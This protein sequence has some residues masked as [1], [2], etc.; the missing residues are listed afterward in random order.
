MISKA[1]CTVF[2][3]ATLCDLSYPSIASATGHIELHAAAFHFQCIPTIWQEPSLKR[4]YCFSFSS[5][6]LCG[7]ASSAH[8]TFSSSSSD[9]S[10]TLL[11]FGQFMM[12]SKIPGQL[13][14][15]IQAHCAISVIQLVCVASVARC[16]EGTLLLNIQHRSGCQAARRNCATVT[17]TYEAA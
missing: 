8:D 2:S 3:S 15:L 14:F 11:P 6:G 7:G 12:T 4:R 17:N 5:S 13:G 1:S 10:L 16:V 9:D